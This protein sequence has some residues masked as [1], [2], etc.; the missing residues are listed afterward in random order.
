MKL[1][2]KKELFQ[3]LSIIIVLTKFIILF[4]AQIMISLQR[5]NL[6]TTKILMNSSEIVLIKI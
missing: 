1:S 2:Q 3:D 5:I 4:A 6:Q